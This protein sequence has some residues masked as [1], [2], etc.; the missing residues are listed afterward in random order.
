MIWRRCKK[1]LE[2][3]WKE[4]TY[5]LSLV[6]IHILDVFCFTVMEFTVL[7]EESSSTYKSTMNETYGLSPLKPCAEINPSSLKLLSSS[8]R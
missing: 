3:S 4:V 7:H 1:K 5:S 2:P 8:V 6:D